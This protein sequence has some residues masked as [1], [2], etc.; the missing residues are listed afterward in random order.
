MLILLTP[1]LL[2]ARKGKKEVREAVKMPCTVCQHPLVVA[3]NRLVAF[4]G[5]ET[6]LVVRERPNIGGRPLAGY[7]CEQCEA[8]HVFATDTNPPE[9]IIANPFEGQAMTNR[10]LECREPLL[11]PPNPQG[12]RDNRLKDLEGLLPKHGL[13]CSR[14]GSVCCIACCQN[15]TRGRTADQSLL[16]PRCYRGPVDKL[17]YF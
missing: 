2:Q 6:S 10:C 15:A 13:V 9:W 5:P 11:R 12:D 4:S 14:C 1:R 7:R 16:C 8:F 3:P 17:H